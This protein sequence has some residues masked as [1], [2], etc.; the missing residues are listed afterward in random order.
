MNKKQRLL[1]E[2]IRRALKQQINEQ[3]P[4][5]LEALS[6]VEMRGTRAPE[7]PGYGVGPEP[8]PLPPVDPAW[9]AYLSQIYG[10]ENMPQNLGYQP[11]FH[12]Y[13]FGTMANRRVRP[14]PTAE[15]TDYWQYGAP[16]ARSGKYR[17]H[18]A[19]DVKAGIGTAVHASLSGIV[20]GAG[21]PTSH[22]NKLAAGCM[23]KYGNTSSSKTR[24]CGAGYGNYIDI[25]S[26]DPETGEMVVTRYAHLEK[27]PA[28][29]GIAKGV[30]VRAGQQIATSGNTGW[31]GGPHLHMEEINADEWIA[32]W[33]SFEGRSGTDTISDW[34]E[35]KHAPTDI[36]KEEWLRQDR[37]EM[38]ATAATGEESLYPGPY[39]A[40]GW[41]HESA[42]P[43][44][45]DEEI[46]AVFGPDV[47]AS[48]SD[49]K[50]ARNYHSLKDD[51]YRRKALDAAIKAHGGVGLTRA[52]QMLSYDP[53]AYEPESFKQFE[54]YEPQEYEEEDVTYDPH[55]GYRP[56]TKG[57]V[58]PPADPRFPWRAD[59][60]T[61]V[62]STEEL[63]ESTRRR[64]KILAGIKRNKT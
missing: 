39:S 45:T 18:N 1:R 2:S 29:M 25:L 62:E 64:F 43:G 35:E 48:M 31:S 56:V 40:A 61:E 54:P 59:P 8:P 34:H 33:G 44:L 22:S 57:E 15:M 3:A 63:Q 19:H 28:E 55:Y 60:E 58:E 38:L 46:S 52:D 32:K 51:R 9:A 41:G 16:R 49:P 4:P 14:V 26:Q 23:K 6:P 30:P 17:S 37:E 21:V 5:G 13:L 47:L 53:G 7:L 24:T 36:E 20:V 10:A 27:D 42:G 12:K 11:D 50:V